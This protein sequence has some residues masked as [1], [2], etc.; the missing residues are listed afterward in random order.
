VRSNG[1]R[2]G[3]D[4]AHGR[5]FIEAVDPAIIEALPISGLYTSVHNVVGYD[6][7]S[8]AARLPAG[9]TPPLDMPNLVRR[10]R[11]DLAGV[12]W[13]D[14]DERAAQFRL[15]ET[16]ERRYDVAPVLEPPVV[17]AGPARRWLAAALQLGTVQRVA[18]RM[19]DR[20]GPPVP[21]YDSPLDAAEAA[22]RHYTE[23]GVGS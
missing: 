19:T 2:Q 4:P 17:S 22:D 20:I 16:A 14:A 6:L 13:T 10:A 12:A 9:S 23:L 21:I 7:A 1:R 11:E 3:S 18:S 15:L 8:S 5:R